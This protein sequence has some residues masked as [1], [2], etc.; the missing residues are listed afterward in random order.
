MTYAVY[1]RMAGFGSNPTMLIELDTG[2]T[3]TTTNQPRA[4][5][6]TCVCPANTG[7]GQS[8]A[9]V[10]L[11]DMFSSN[12]LVK[13]NGT[14]TL[15]CTDIGGSQVY[16]F[17]Y[18]ILVPVTNTATLR[19]YISA[20]Y[21]YP[22]AKGVGVDGSISFTIANRYNDGQYQQHS[23]VVESNNVSPLVLSNNSAGTMVSYTLSQLLAP[24]STNTLRAIF[25]DSAGVSMTNTWTFTTENPPVIPT[26]YAQPIG[27]EANRGFGIFIV[28]G[29]DNATGS[30]FPPT[31]A[32]AEQQ[33]AGTLTNSITLQPYANEAL[34]NG[35]YT[36]TNVINYDINLMDTAPLILNSLTNFPDI[37]TAT[38]NIA[39]EA[40]MYVQLAAGVY[41]FGVT[42]D[43]GFKLSTGPTPTGTNLTLGVFDG[44]RPSSETTFD[45]IVQTN[46][47]YPMRLLYFKSQLGGDD[48]EFY[49]ISRTNGTRILINDSEQYEC[50][51]GFPGG[52]HHGCKRGT[53]PES[54]AQRKCNTV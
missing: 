41:T 29:D 40:E 30:D 36:E 25:K 46:G 32:R 33:L 54:F 16:N 39:M 10:P 51:Q 9:F 31:V 22:S 35:L 18:L 44:G 37:A 42:S 11:T 27:S 49:S 26:S 4:A 3:A 21:P 17:N 47:L 7:G 23:V 45:F 6:G 13:F 5:L 34:N 19:P 38:N 14:N 1:A 43:D 48:L 50:H 8:Y 52:Y 12:V 53:N 20:G 28:K 2:A 24:N 15:R